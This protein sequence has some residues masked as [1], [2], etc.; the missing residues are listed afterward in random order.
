MNIEA[1]IQDTSKI[2]QAESLMGKGVKLRQDI[3]TNQDL[4][5]TNLPVT[6]KAIRNVNPPDLLNLKLLHPLPK[7][8]EMSPQKQKPL[9]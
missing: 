1:Q 7:S 3:K 5:L 8:Q 4:I 2:H 9:A 6:L